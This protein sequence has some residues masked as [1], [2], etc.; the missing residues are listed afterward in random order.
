L[1]GISQSL[2]L[3]CIAAA[4]GANEADPTSFWNVEGSRG[5]LKNNAMAVGVIDNVCL[6]RESWNE[7]GLSRLGPKPPEERSDADGSRVSSLYALDRLRF[8]TM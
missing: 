4:A 7:E 2:S 8:L 1:L 6:S 5:L 3:T